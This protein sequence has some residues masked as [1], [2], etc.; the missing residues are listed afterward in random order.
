MNE[1]NS[2][3][4]LMSNYYEEL[5]EHVFI[6]EILQEAWFRFNKSVEVLHSE[7]DDS[8]YDLV[9]ECNGVLRHVQLKI[10]IAGGSRSNVNINMGLMGKPSGCI[11]WITRN[12]DEDK[13]R[14]E[15]EYLF[16][17]NDPGYPLP[18]ISDLK[19]SKHTK[20]DSQGL[21]KERPM[22]REVPKN[23]FIELKSIKELVEA[24]FG[25]TEPP[26]S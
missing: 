2:D 8:G 10:S 12:Y 19:V 20:A 5:V 14:I 3:A 17:G 15:L 21:K 9:L 26:N 11:V 22:I 4:Y 1:D 23:K 13:K 16:F 6:S 18:D 7:I 24:L 25:L